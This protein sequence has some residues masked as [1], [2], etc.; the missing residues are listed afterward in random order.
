MRNR[1]DHLAKQIGQKALGPSGTTVTQ[2]AI[3]PETQ[4]ADLRHEPDPARQKERD[5]LGLLGQLAAYPCLIE[6]YS[7]APNADE[8]RAC[9]TKHL[10]AWQ[11][12]VRKVRSEIRRQDA[13][14]PS[15]ESSASFLWIIAAGAPTSLVTKLKLE[16]SPRW[17]PG[18]YLFGDDILR[19][20]IVV[21][22]ELPRDRMSLLVRLMAAGPLLAP[23]IKEV[24]ALPPDAFERAIAEPILLQFQHVLAQDSSRD[25]DEQ[26]FIMAMLKSWEE[27]KAEARVE[28]RV[29]AVLT[30]LR[31]R[32]I[33]VPDAARQRI[34]AEKD[35]EQLKR[36]LEKAI[37]AS[38]I[39]EVIDDAR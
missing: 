4:Y 18:V 2:D 17:P 8:F 13:P 5:R 12:R 31:V 34:V 7:Q 25:P 30:A 20:G 16:R 10:A 22:S 1:F 38:S 26:E 24:A 32:G 33:A 21:A 29:D 36:W 14:L 27:A 37:L 28:A 39:A 35:L 15:E 3:N 23:A 9:L 6:V 11:Q 19:V